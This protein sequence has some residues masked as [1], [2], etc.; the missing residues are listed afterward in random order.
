MDMLS[1][2]KEVMGKREQNSL[3]NRQAILSAARVCFKELGYENT[4][5]RDLIR[6]TD[7]ASGTFYNYFRSKRDIF[8][9]LL[10]DFLG[11]LNEHLIQSRRTANTAEEFIHRSYLALYSATARDP[12]VYE[13]AHRND[14]A[15]N[16]LFGS[17]ILRLIMISLEDD[18]R[19]AVERKVLPDVDQDYLCTAFFGVAYE[20][21]LVLAGRVH[22]NPERGDEEV[23]MATC[24]S[25]TLFIGGLERLAA[26][27]CERPLP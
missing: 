13:L 10:A 25:T 21:S 11:G 17:G 4:T 2:K 16:E 6:K 1:S 19:D 18:V 20:A 26:L 9:A 15:L 23:A 7:L 14:R 22:E 5:I 3:R 27:P 24:F 8:A 12:L